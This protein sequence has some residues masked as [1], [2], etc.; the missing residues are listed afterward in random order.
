MGRA[1]IAT[2]WEQFDCYTKMRW[3]GADERKD[4]IGKSSIRTRC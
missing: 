1:H 2:A 3:I 4:D